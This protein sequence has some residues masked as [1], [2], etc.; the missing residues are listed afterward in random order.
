MK[1][2]VDFFPVVLFFL[3]YKLYDIYVATAVAIAA[4]TL[5]VGWTWF[6]HG[7]A[8]VMHLVTLALL[9]VFGG[10]TIVLQDRAFIMWKP[11]IVNWLF[12]V[13]F[14]GSQYIG[15]RPLIER[16]MG[17]AVDL[18]RKIWR[19]INL[20]WTAFFV[21][22]GLANLYVANGFFIAEK[23]LISASGQREID[24]A[25]CSQLFSGEILRLCMS[26]QSREEIWV[27]FKLFGMMGLTI[28]FVVAQG[29]YM[30]RHVRDVE[31]RVESD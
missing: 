1:L 19:Q 20:S 21:F 12:A 16:M 25:A 7:R 2:L 23:A 31:K 30:A 8:E 22:A 5:Q 9:A 24:L 15:G 3:A 14:L 17:H 26:A 6:R 13:V 18:P 28:A 10:L 11:S 29:F 27:N 4:S